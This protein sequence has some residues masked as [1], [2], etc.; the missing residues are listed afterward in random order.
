MNKYLAT[1]A[2][3]ALVSGTAS[4]GG[5]DRSGQGVN[6]LFE[7]G[8][9]MQMTYSHVSPDVNGGAPTIAGFAGASTN[10]AQSYNYGSFG[11]KQKL[12]D[13]LDIALIIDQPFGAHILYAD[14]PF[15]N[16]G[17]AG[18]PY[19]ATADI[20][21]HAITGLLQY[22]F[23]NGFSVHGGVRALTIDGTI[24]SSDG[25]L[26]ASS[27][28]DF[29]GVIG[30]AYEKP[31]IALRFALTYSSAIDS[32][33][34]SSQQQ[35]VAL[36]PAAFNPTNPNFDLEF[37][38]SVNLDFQTGIAKNTLL[39]GSV[40][41]VGWGGFSLVTPGLAG[42]IEW[43]NFDDDTVSYEIGVGHRINEK[44]SLAVTLGFEEPGSRP[45]ST[46]L[47]PTTGSTS[48][49]LGGTYQATEKL[50]ISGGVRYIVPG[51]QYVD[52]TSAGL[53]EIHFDDN[54][55]IAAGFRIGYSF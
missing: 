20:D 36:G 23:D 33:F 7:E 40:R 13:R 31:E 48:I 15:S 6:I 49:G 44:L 51:D 16:G 38:E 25:I 11:Y 37:P 47:S 10:V 42:D 30:A 29:G 21:S 46:A 39:F 19:D 18:L 35:L 8:T 53:G 27:D 34:S 24:E 14:G 3:L 28:Y 50:S 55:A 2:M 54:S 43:V 9:Y 45:T 5:I 41:W 1:S 22:N 32:S 17:V 4:A 52:A 12:T 26:N